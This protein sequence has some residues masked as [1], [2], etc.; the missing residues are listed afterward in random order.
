MNKIHSGLDCGYCG[1][2]LIKQRDSKYLEK[3][4]EAKFTNKLD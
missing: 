3:G 2:K 4:E 1:E